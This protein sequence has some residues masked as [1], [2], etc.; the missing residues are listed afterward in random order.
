[1]NLIKN[2]ICILFLVSFFSFGFS[3]T[4]LVDGVI[5]NVQD[6]IEVVELYDDTKNWFIFMLITGFTAICIVT[7]GLVM[8]KINLAREKLD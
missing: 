6:T 5:M 3:E 1:M 2:L 4:V 8:R 7:M